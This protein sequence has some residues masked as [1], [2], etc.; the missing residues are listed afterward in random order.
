MTM[1]VLAA[2]N[3]HGE[4][5]VEYSAPFKG[6]MPTPPGY[7]Y[8]FALRRYRNLQTGRFVSTRAIYELMDARL[9]ASGELMNILSGV[10][11]SRWLQPSAWLM[12]MQEQLRRL[13]V[14]NAALGAGGI[15]QIPNSIW[16]DIDR[17]LR[18]ETDRLAL[19]G[20][21]ILAGKLSPAQIANRIN[22]YLGTAR[23]WYFKALPTPRVRVNQMILERR[24]LGTADHCSY[25][26]YLAGLG[27][28]PYGVL[29]RP[30]E[31]SAHWD[32]DQC[33][34]NCRCS[35]ITR[36]VGRKRGLKML[37]QVRPFTASVTK[38]VWRDFVLP[39]NMPNGI[40]HDV[41]G[42]SREDKGADNGAESG[43]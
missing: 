19:F 27:W 15:E 30:G 39:A 4:Y 42:I 25:C 31:S 13:H 2:N 41:Y 21:E 14:Q 11:N 23:L 9:S 22:M 29:P 8:N 12:A 20:S 18:D 3:G 5:I 24:V 28:Q 7:S 10:L 40:S 38:S 1:E 16:L 6:A 36:V 43:E 26:I 17:K 33:L 37:S 32:D 35:I 34:S